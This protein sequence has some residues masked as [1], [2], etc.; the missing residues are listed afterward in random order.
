[1]KIGVNQSVSQKMLDA[2]EAPTVR[3]LAEI[4]KV[5]QSFMARVLR[6]KDLAPESLRPFW[7]AELLSR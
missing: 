3:K 4:E 7:M 6:M 1:M 2:R 5:D